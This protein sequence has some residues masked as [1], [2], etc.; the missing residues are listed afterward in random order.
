VIVSCKQCGNEFAPKPK[1][2][3]ARYCSDTCKRRNQRARL[4]VHNPEQLRSA[5]ARSY[6][7][8]KKHPD[9]LDRHR[10]SGRKT[11]RIARVWLASYKMEYGCV[12]CGYRKHSAALQLDHEGNKSVEISEARSSIGRLQA[13][14]K[15]GKCKVRCAN[16][17]AIRTWQC[18]QVAS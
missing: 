8:T 5:R 4:L 2:Y 9:R 1:G 16:C 3:N 14:I 15:I 18:K 17:H 11:R 10:K 13:E 6:L 7:Q 12:D